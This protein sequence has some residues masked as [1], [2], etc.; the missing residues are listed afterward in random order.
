MQASACFFIGGIYLLNIPIQSLSGIGEKTE[1]KLN[2]IDIY[3]VEDLMYHVPI[4]YEDGS[5]LASFKNAEL[6][7]SQTYYA[8]I[9]EKGPIRYIRKGLKMQN[10]TLFD[11]ETFADMTLFNMPYLD[12]KMRIGKSYYIYGKPKF[13]KN[14]LQFSTPK[15]FTDAEKK[16]ALSITPIYS[17]PKGITQ[18]SMANFIVNALSEYKIPSI[19]PKYLLKR[20]GLLSED[21]AI[22]AIHRPQSIEEATLAKQSLIFSEFLCFQ[23]ALGRFNLKKSKNGFTMKNERLCEDIL[24][25]LP[26]QLTEGQISAWEDIRCD[27]KSGKRMERLVQGD[28]GSGKTIIAFL[29]MA[30]AVSSGYQAMLMAPTEILAKQ[31][32]QDALDLF[33]PQGV[34][35]ELLTGSTKAKRKND[36]LEN[37]ETGACDILIGT[38]TLFQENI[39]VNR[40][41]L[42]ICD[43]QHRFG[44]LQRE[45]LQEKQ[46][47][48]HRLIMTATPIPRSLGIVMYG[49]TDISSIRTMPKGR[50]GVATTIVDEEGLN[51]AYNF[52]E[53][54]LKD[55]QQVYVVCP[56]IEENPDLDLHAAETMY[57][58]FK[59]KRFKQFSVGLLHG[60]MSVEE[61]NKIMED[62]HSGRIQILISTTVIEVGVNVVN[63]N[64]LFVFDADRFG[65][66]TLHQLRGRVGRG[67]QKAFCILHSANKSLK[68][69]QRLG[70]LARSNDGFY[71]AEE[72]MKTRGGGD[73]F[74]TRQSGMFSFRVG[75]FVENMDIMRYAK[76]EADAIL[77]GNHLNFSEEPALL[78]GVIAYE[79]RVLGI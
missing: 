3:T 23:L 68:A 79:N 70:I 11:G 66:A 19:I 1:K 76:M 31:H 34:R 42:T 47:Q 72:D 10:F 43:E 73:F 60:Q 77:K 15:I 22:H 6:N 9:V 26:F 33:L 57:A 12:G 53:S 41:G 16:K 54:Y 61:K 18:A 55:N 49:S 59:K 35:V 5:R 65:L 28:V 46:T 56:L 14:R 21:K 48:S 74:G 38:H 37:F 27:M 62:F 20:Y 25:K 44:V 67:D 8:E 24:N 30:M 51:T 50:R 52:I 7:E 40:L 32:Y 2:G 45:R 75:D 69:Q 71:I 78:E 13:F 64:L 58:V 17:L 36:I 63:A 4:R 29:A 39:Q